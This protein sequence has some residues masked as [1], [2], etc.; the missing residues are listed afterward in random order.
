MKFT[1]T[2]T[3]VRDMSVRSRIADNLPP[4]AQNPFATVLITP[5]EAG[6]I[7]VPGVA[8]QLVDDEGLQPFYVDHH[9]PAYRLISN[10]AALQCAYRLFEAAK[11]PF[12]L[13]E[14]VWDGHRFSALFLAQSLTEN[15]SG[16]DGQDLLTLGV[17]IQ[18]SYNASLLFSVRFL[19]YRQVCTNGLMVGDQLGSFAFKHV[20]TTADDG[21]DID[22]TDAT[23]ALAGG[24]ERYHDLLPHFHAMQRKPA[25]LDTLQTWVASLSKGTPS[26]P[27]SSFANVMTRLNRKPSVWEM[28]NAFTYVSTHDLHPFHGADLSQRVCTLALAEVE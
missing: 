26:W 24:I 15:L 8:L 21:F 22:I 6:G 18:N 27:A 14:L 23:A 2:T 7:K 5:L 16:A 25:S 11:T 20:A 3:R 12:N 1:T 9:S 19:V 4:H 10:T 28:L 13:S 17:L